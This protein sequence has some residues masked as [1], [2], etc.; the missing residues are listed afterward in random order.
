MVFDT[1]VVAYALLGTR[2][3]RDDS[4]AALAKAPDIV[5]PDSFRAELT[6]VLWQWVR[7]RGVPLDHA[8]SLLRSSET[9][10]NEFVSSNQLAEQALALA[11]QNDVSAYDALFITLA[12]QRK[13][14][15]ITCDKKVLR[16]FASIAVTPSTYVGRASP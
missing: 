5:V 1:M 8:V 12:I 7:L 14:K 9:L 10:V 11:V 4:M 2:P 15:L 16:K 3:F 6:N 13:T